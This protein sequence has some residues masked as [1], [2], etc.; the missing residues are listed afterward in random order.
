MNKQFIIRSDAI[1]D[2][3]AGFLTKNW[4]GFFD[5]KKTLLVTV[6]FYKETR[7]NQQNRHLHALLQNIAD[8]AWLDGRQ[9]PMEI[10]KEH[11]KRV[12]LGVIELPNGEL[13]AHPTRKLSYDE[14][15]DFIRKIEAHAVSEL[16]VMLRSVNWA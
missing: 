11:F 16:G 15:A 9:Y 2:N 14:C 7:D 8:D 6:T 4:R 10:W 5:D 3:L 1:I 12:F 13:M